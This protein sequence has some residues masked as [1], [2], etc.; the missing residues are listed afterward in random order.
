MKKSVILLLLLS[1]TAFC[2]GKAQLIVVGGSAKDYG[3]IRDSITESYYPGLFDH[4]SAKVPTGTFWNYRSEMCSVYTPYDSIKCMF[5]VMFS[6]SGS[7]TDYKVVPDPDG[8]V[9]AVFLFYKDCTYPSTK[10]GYTRFL[11]IPFKRIKKK[12]RIK[13]STYICCEPPTYPKKE[14]KRLYGYIY[15]CPY[16]PPLS[17]AEIWV[18]HLPYSD[19][20][21]CKDTYTR[22]GMMKE[23]DQKKKYSKRAKI[24]YDNIA[25]RNR[26]RT[27]RWKRTPIEK[28]RDKFYR[29][30]YTKG[31]SKAEIK[32]RDAQYDAWEKDRREATRKR[33]QAEYRDWLRSGSFR[34]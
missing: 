24:Y 1:A 14:I 30:E 4:G 27:H 22:E 31:K 10:K 8:N 17:T 5:E 7:P 2:P 21:K 12:Y 11:R 26:Y 3:H 15:Y 9:G 32:K 19:K 23:R 33:K 16:N 18:D 28:K 20:L 29:E 6:V 34:Q 25:I 13:F